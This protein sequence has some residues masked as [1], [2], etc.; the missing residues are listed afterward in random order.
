MMKLR[1]IFLLDVSPVKPVIVEDEAGVEPDKPVDDGH[2]CTEH[3]LAIVTEHSREVYSKDDN[4]KDDREDVDNKPSRYRFRTDR[5][6]QTPHE[7]PQ[8]DQI[9]EEISPR[10]PGHQG[11]SCQNKMCQKY[12]LELLSAYFWDFH[13]H[14]HCSGHLAV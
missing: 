7:T 10:S 11:K 8:E 2:D 9:G 13:L 1:N 5:L 3:H 12:K 4:V 6:G 14:I